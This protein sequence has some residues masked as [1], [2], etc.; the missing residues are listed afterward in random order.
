MKLKQ[1]IIESYQDTV[2]SPEKWEHIKDVLERNCKPFIKELKGVKSL[3]YRGINRNIKDLKELPVRVDRTPR[4]ISMDLHKRLGDY[5][6]KKFGWNMRT[7]GLFCTSSLENARE[8]AKA[9]PIIVFPVGNYKYMWNDDIWKLYDM[10]DK[11]D[12]RDDVSIAPY[13][14]R[15]WETIQYEID[16]YQTTNLNKYLKDPDPYKTEVV[17]KCKTYY[18]INMMWK[19]T[20]LGYFS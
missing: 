15:E 18:A 6:K 4:F 2:P 14:N 3:V 8:F 19:E 9:S 13:K 17:F 10:Y 5:S 11:W 20:L 7:E 12:D 16:Q 1:Y